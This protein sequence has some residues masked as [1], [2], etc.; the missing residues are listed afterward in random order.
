LKGISPKTLSE[1][2]KELQRFGVIN[3]EAFAEIPPRV[4]YSL[5]S[6]GKE[7]VGTFKNLD[8]FMNKWEKN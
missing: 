3:K 6:K 2:L 8:N 1:R 7:L 4:Q 5:T